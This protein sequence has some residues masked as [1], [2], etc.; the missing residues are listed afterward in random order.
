[1]FADHRIIARQSQQAGGLEVLAQRHE[2]MWPDGTAVQLHPVYANS[3]PM[4]T[5]RALALPDGRLL[6]FDLAHLVRR[7]D[8]EL[9]ACPTRDLA[10]H[11]FYTLRQAYRSAGQFS[12]DALRHAKG[13]FWRLDDG[14]VWQQAARAIESEMPDIAAVSVP[15]HRGLAG[16]LQTLMNAGP[17]C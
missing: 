9:R 7:L 4:L 8:G 5:L 3:L 15:R 17:Q 6:V 13:A 16:A 14:Y 10:G 12:A 2:V 1:M 11:V